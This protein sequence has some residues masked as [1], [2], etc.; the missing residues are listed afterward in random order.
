MNHGKNKE[1][2]KLINNNHNNIAGIVI[3]K[4]GATLYENYFNKCSADSRIHV[5]SVSKSI[6]SILIGIAMDKGH[7]NSVN[8]RVLDFF[9]DYM[10]KR[11]E[12]VIQNITLKDM[13]TMSVPYKYKFPP[14]THIR[15]FMSNDW[16]KFALNLIGGRK[17]V[18]E[19]KYTPLIGPDIFSGIIKKAT[20]QSVLGFATENLFYPLG[21][22]VDSSIVFRTAKEQFAFNKATNI[23]GWVSDQMGI[24]AGGWGL[25]LSAMDM[26]KIGQLYLDGG[27]WGEKQIVSTSW[28]DESTKEHSRW[29][30]INLAYG[31]LW[32]IID[33][34]EQAFAA[35]GDGGNMIY[36]N[37]KKDIVVS[38]ASLFD[39]K[40]KDRARLVQD[41]I[42]IISE[43]ANAA[44]S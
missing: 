7:I 31:Y 16:V 21:I 34:K 25:T 14:Y 43:I 6:I 44:F 18:G 41:R 4:N 38:I 12:K 42:D 20:G 3:L 15:Y 8:Q 9:S 35:I 37:T 10:P 19:F 30:E 2:E 39:P 24:N 32:W 28:I 27:L 17:P 33:N 11:N 36:V 13:L 26:A 23:S 29:K 40:V 5:Y 1:L 22:T